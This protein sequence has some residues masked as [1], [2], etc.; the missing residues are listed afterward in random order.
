MKNS[1]FQREGEGGFNIQ[2]DHFKIPEGS[3]E[4]TFGSIKKLK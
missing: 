1:K 4:G 2:N 3:G